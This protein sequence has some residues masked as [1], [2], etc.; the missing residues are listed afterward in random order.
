MIWDQAFELAPLPKGFHPVTN[1]ILAQTPAHI[2]NVLA[3]PSLIIR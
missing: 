2:K 1:E 3:G